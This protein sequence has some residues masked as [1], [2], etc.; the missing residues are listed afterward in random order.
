MAPVPEPDQNQKN[1]ARAGG[2]VSA[3][4]LECPSLLTAQFLIY[5]LFLM[6]VATPPPP[7]RMSPLTTPKSPPGY[8]KFHIVTALVIIFY[9]DS[10]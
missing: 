9:C 5:L 2:T 1:A 8:G 4:T 10:L 6:A 7:L 3:V